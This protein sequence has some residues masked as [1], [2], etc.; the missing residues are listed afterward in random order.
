MRIRRNQFRHLLRGLTVPLVASAVV[1]AGV[2]LAPVSSTPAAADIPTRTAQIELV[3]TINTDSTAAGISDSTLYSMSQADLN[4][5]RK[6]TRL[7]SSH[8]QKSRMPSSA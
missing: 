1:A 6:S 3:A 4:T 5:D 2:G 7:N 8:I